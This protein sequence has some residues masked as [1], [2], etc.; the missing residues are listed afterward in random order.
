MDEITKAIYALD[1]RDF[2]DYVAIIF[3]VLSSIAMMATFW[4]A[5]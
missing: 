2:W 3:G 5:K 1:Q 4:L